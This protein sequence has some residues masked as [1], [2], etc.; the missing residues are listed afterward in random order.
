LRLPHGR[1]W[2]KES[3]MPLGVERIAAFLHP[4]TAL[5]A[6]AM[7][8]YAAS[9][10]LRARER[11]G[12]PL[13]LRHAR[14]APWAFAAILASAAF[15]AVSTWLW[16]PDLELG[17]GWHA[18]LALA[19]ATLLAAAAVASRSIAANEAARRLHPVLGL[20]ALLLALVQVFVGLGLLPL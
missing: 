4:A 1:G 7:L 9:L 15:G 5:L 2:N 11:G 13:R 20:A 3:A 8:A 16:R 12:A 6:I 14:L 10:G 18:R 19:I 17:Q